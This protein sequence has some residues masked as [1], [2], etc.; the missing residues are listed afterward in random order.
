MIPLKRFLSRNL[1]VLIGVLIGAC[2]LPFGQ[3][4]ATQ[5]PLEP[6]AP[7]ESPETGIAQIDSLEVVILESFPVQVQAL[8]HGSLPD[9]CTIIVERL[10]IRQG[11]EFLVS[12]VTN[13]PAEA[14]CAQTI[15]PFD[16][17][18]SLDV[19]GLA[20]GTYTVVAGNVS[21]AFELSVDNTLST[22]TAQAGSVAGAVWN[23]LCTV[24][25]DPPVPAG[26]CAPQEDG[27]FLANGLRDSGETGVP[28]IEVVLKAEL[29][30]GADLARRTTDAAGTYLFDNLPPGVY[31]LVIDSLANPNSAVL[32][33]GNW[34]YPLGEQAETSGGAQTGHLVDL[35]A[36]QTASGV[37]FGWW[38]QFAAAATPEPVV[39]PETCTNQASFVSET[40][41]DDTVVP[42][43][44][45]FT[46]SWTLQNKGTCTW[47]SNYALIFVDGDQLGAVSPFPIG[48]NVP[49]GEELTVAVPMT[50]PAAAGTYRGDWL[51]RDDDGQNFGLGSDGDDTF[52]V[53]IVTEG[54]VV[55]LN[56]GDPDWTDDFEDGLFWFLL[57]NNTHEFNLEDS[58]LEMKA[59]T[60]GGGEQWGL[61]LKPAIADFYIEATFTTGP[62]CS[63]LDRYGL[64]VRAPDPNAGY[65]FN[66]ACNG[67]FRV[68]EWDGSLFQPLQNWTTSS[69]IHTGA[70]AENTL[71]LWLVDDEIK[72]YINGSLI[73]EF[74]D[75]TYSA[76]QFGLLIGSANTANFKVDV[77]EVSYWL[78]ED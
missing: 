16:E 67:Q 63:G 44:Q 74:S 28:G 1:N 41:E 34:T 24:S 48:V 5:S 37:D 75:A 35:Q 51:L 54:T 61:S 22:E 12:L 6:T 66:L 59:I 60:A 73:A 29:C 21:A 70:N 68:Y 15:M 52:W 25:G 55:E 78:I 42:S 58:Y 49:P 64:L 56:L 18:I 30:S 45:P 50:A 38:F 69:A 26:G 76:G 43:G 14:A 11:S 19:F 53:Q 72:V 47:N 27:S 20:A 2:T 71:G 23:D 31:C 77:E 39:N 13:R 9:A 40:I 46:K 32:I 4:P 10:A 17:V 8:A 7:L 65:V 33:P 57:D 3:Q 62:K 36:G